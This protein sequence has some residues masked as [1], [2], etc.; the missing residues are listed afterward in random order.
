MKS[1]IVFCFLFLG[2]LPSMLAQCP[3]G[4]IIITPINCNDGFVDLEIDF[5]FSLMPSDSFFVTINNT[6]NGPFAYADLGI[7]I[8]N[9]FPFPPPNN[10]S[11]PFFEIEIED[12]TNSLCSSITFIDTDCWPQFIFDLVAEPTN[13]ASNI[14]LF[15]IDVEFE[16]DPDYTSDYFFVFLD[17]TTSPFPWTQSYGPFPYSLTSNS[18]TTVGPLWGNGSSI[19]NVSIIDSNTFAPSSTPVTAAAPACC[20]LSNIFVEALPCESDGTFMAEIQFAYENMPSDSFQLTG[21]GMN[22]GTFNYADNTPNGNGVVMMT[23]GPLVGDG[24]MIYEFIVTDSENDDCSID[25]EFWESIDCN[26]DC[27]ITDLIVEAHPCD[28]DQFLVDINFNYQNM[29][30][31]SFHLVGNGTN[32][33]TFAYADLWLTFGPILGDGNTVFEFVVIDSENNDCTA[34]TGLDPIDCTGGDC[35]IWDLEVWDFECNN[36]GTYNLNLNFNYANVNNDFFDVFANGEFFGY[37]AFADLPIHIENFPASGNNFDAI[38]VCQNDLPTCCE[39]LEFEAPE[40]SNSDCYGFEDL[41]LNTVY[42]TPDY[43]NDDLIFTTGDIPVKFQEFNQQGSINLGSIYVADNNLPFNQY[44]NF[45]DNFLRIDFSNLEFN[46]LQLG[47]AVVHAEFDFFAPG[48]WVNMSANDAPTSEAASFFNLDGTEI[49]PGVTL[50]VVPDPN[51]SNAGKVVIDGFMGLLTIG[52]DNGLSIDNLCLEYAAIGDCWAGDTNSD[53]IA[54]NFDLLNIGLAYG[55]EGTPRDDASI[56]WVAQ[57]SDDWTQTFEDGTNYKHADANGDGIINAQDKFAIDENFGLTH[58]TVIS[59][60]SPTPSA[61][62]PALFIVMPNPNDI[63][64]GAFEAEIHL[65]ASANAIDA[66]YG[67]AFTVEF[68][69]QIFDAS[70]MEIAFESG[71][72]NNNGTDD[73]LSVQKE[74]DGKLAAAVTRINQINI[75]GGGKIGTINGIIDDLSGYSEIDLGIINVKGITTSETLVPFNTP[76][77]YVEVSTGIIENKIGRNLSIFP[78]PANDLIFIKNE[79][80]APIENI[81]LINILGQ[82]VLEK[83]VNENGMIELNINQISEGIYFL[84]IKVDGFKVTR[85]I[86]IFR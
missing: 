58:G 79:N 75:S 62:D 55:A 45:V 78:N 46:F 23:F 76:E 44:P 27:E 34:A 38:K 52:G 35:E 14:G 69:N 13:C 42:T 56:A 10:N 48:A 82:E 47:Q 63:G 65:G 30:S 32:Y 68:N 31:D 83:S 80:K 41:D 36:D 26:D 49:A 8:T 66:I 57:P 84:E 28:G 86:E 51:N 6:Q 2:C 60:V 37:Y 11:S 12:Q 74:E 22:Y 17:N 20:Q 18:T 53:F 40:C 7:T 5:N 70:S 16:I 54:N 15:Y 4:D 29:P 9:Q 67:L 71:W 81:R 61:D 50:T 43:Q 85:K 19:Y 33:G 64:L 21:N 25:F 24:T 77:N 3:P 39:T 73:L 1:F 59:Y 72:F